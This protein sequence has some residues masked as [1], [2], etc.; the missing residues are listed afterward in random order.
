[1]DVLVANNDGSPRL[2]LNET[3]SRSHWIGLR[4]AGK[5]GS[6]ARSP[7]QAAAG[8]DMLGARVGVVLDGGRTLWRRVHTDG[9]YASASDPRVVVGLGASTRV[10]RIRVVWPSGASEE[11]TAGEVDRFS[12]LEEGHAK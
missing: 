7:R 9:S 10:A 8:R 11:W 3:G 6:D 2:L 1:V 5:R 4:L 12:T